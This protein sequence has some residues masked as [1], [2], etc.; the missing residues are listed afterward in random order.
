MFVNVMFAIHRQRVASN[1]WKA[2][3]RPESRPPS[4]SSKSGEED[5]DDNNGDD[6]DVGD[7]DDKHGD[8]DTDGGYNYCCGYQS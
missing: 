7:D 4:Q 5:D 1:H 6:N 2:A 8:D 3:D